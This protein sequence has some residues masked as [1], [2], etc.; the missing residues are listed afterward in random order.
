MPDEIAHPAPAPRARPLARAPAPA[1]RS[2]AVDAHGKHLFLRFEGDLVHPLAPAHDRRLA[3]RTATGERWRRAPRRA[4]LVLRAGGHEVVQF[5]GPV[6]ELMTES[7]HAL[8][9]AP[10]GARARHRSPTE[11]DEQAVLRRLRDDDP[12]RAIGDA[13]L[14]QRTVAGIGNMWKARRCCGGA[15]R[16]VAPDRS[17]SPTTRCWRSS[18]TRARGCSRQRQRR[19]PAHAT[20]ASTAAPAGRARAA[21]TPIRAP[22]PGRRQPHDLLVPACQR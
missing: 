16:P 13:L 17:T 1:G 4:W 22:R 8:R 14:D 2:T 19:P 11:F 12:T 20:S 15:G 18:A 21:A 5:D 7:P 3:V 6:L 10:R 9:P